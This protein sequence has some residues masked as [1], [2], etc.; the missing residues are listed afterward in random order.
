MWRHGTSILQTMF[1]AAA[2]VC[3]LFAVAMLAL[4]FDYHRSAPDTPMAFGPTI[5]ATETLW[6]PE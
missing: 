1:G 3:P 5:G 2:L 4:Q 6:D